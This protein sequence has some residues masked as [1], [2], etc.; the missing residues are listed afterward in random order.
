MSYD[1]SFNLPTGDHNAKDNAPSGYVRFMVGLDGV[2]RTKDS[3]GN[4][5]V[6]ATGISPEEVQDI[7]GAF[8]ASSASITATYND[9]GNVMSFVVN[10]SSIDHGNISNLLAD[11]HTQY[12]NNTRGDARYYTK[13]ANDI[14]LAGKQDAST[15]GST[16]LGLL[17][18]GYS[19]G[20]N[21]VISATDSIL[22]AF[23]KIQAQLNGKE[24][25]ISSGTT[26]QYWR[27]DK[28]WQTHDKASVGLSLVPNV[29]ATNPANTVQTT[30]FRYVSDAEKTNWNSKEPALNNPNNTSLYY[31][32]DKTWATFPTIPSSLSELTN[33]A[34]FETTTQLNLR[35]TA[36]RS[37]ANHTGTQL[38]STISD[39][40]SGV[41]SSVLTGISFATNSAILATDT[42]LVA[43]GK[44]QAQLNNHFGSGG[45]VHALATTTVAGFMSALDKIKLDGIIS[46]VILILESSLTNT[47]NVTFT[48]ITA[49]QIPV[50]AGQRYK[51][52]AYLLFDSN[53]NGTG[54]GLSIGGTATGTL[55]SV[56]EAPVSNNAGTANKLSGPINALNGVVT[57]TG[58]GAVGTQYRAQIEGVFTATSNGFIYPQFRSETNGTQVRVNIDSNMVYKEY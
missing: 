41:M 51:F 46:D 6:Y 39:F 58:V 53:A 45:T 8:I 50:V 25:T 7:V 40:L 49:L 10:Q 13:T 12:L 31:R 29:D 38:V 11:H 21:A 14:L 33:D 37:R 4:V 54:I 30:S 22:G 18:S 1:G 23:Q 15:L 28:T 27:G 16:V 55:R 3:I 47:S 42:L 19:I 56:A 36:N 2:L 9:A 24:P 35:D 44:L 57:T 34:N 32:G 17:L 52:E 43:I 5:T 26:S 20:A 48:T